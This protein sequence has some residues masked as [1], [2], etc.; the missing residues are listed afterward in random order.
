LSFLPGHDKVTC[1]FC[2]SEYDI[3]TLEKMFAEQQA[4]AAAA[5]QAEAEKAQKEKA[6]RAAEAAAAGGAVAGG[7]AGEAGAEGA[8]GDASHGWDTGAAGQAWGEG[9]T[10]NF[11]T[12][13]CSSC[14]AELVTDGNTM[15]T[16][17]CYCG[18]PTMIPQRFDGALK[19][20][21]IIPF[22]KTKEEAVKALKEFYKGK[23]LLP[24]AFT[25]NNRVDAIQG[26]YVPF[27]LFDTKVHALVNYD[28]SNTRS[29][30]DGGDDVT[31]TEY[32]NCSREG[33]LAFAKIP[34]DG[35]KKMDDDYMDSIEPFDYSEM[36]PFTTAYLTSYLADKYDVTAEDCAGR[37]N[38]RVESST[39]EEVGKTMDYESF[40]VTESQ[41]EKT[42]G[43][44][45][46]AMV[47]VWIL[48]TKYEG[49]PYTFMM[50]GQTGKF[51]GSLPSDPG[52]E[53]KYMAIAFAACFVV[54]T[55]IMHLIL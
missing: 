25:A 19:P 50:N 18:N 40:D 6:A 14:G 21:F 15:A 2:G 37:I 17:C 54:V 3:Q 49:K 31:E 36:Q 47:P 16:E 33:N 27:W 20:D 41:I 23:K 29:Y 28:A 1:E 34:S 7:A 45:K 22:K 10:E 44:V 43:E 9:E 32:Y 51:I 5:A 4:K 52:K 39:L 11:Q 24:D 55:A 46:Y 48:T 30:Q 35:S 53:K 12:F 8:A 42:E 13:V 26:L 38:E